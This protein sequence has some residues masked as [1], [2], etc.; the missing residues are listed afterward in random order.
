[1][2]SFRIMRRHPEG[3]LFTS[4]I[5]KHLE[6]TN[7]GQN[8]Q[9]LKE[10]LVPPPGD[11][12]MSEEGIRALIKPEDTCLIDGMAMGMKMLEDAGY[13]PRL[14]V[15]QENDEEDAEGGKAAMLQLHGE[16]D[17]TG[18]GLGFS[19][20]RTSMKGGYLEQLQHGP[21]SSAA[22]MMEKQKRDNNG[23][24][25]NV[26]KQEQA[27]KTGISEI[28]NKQKT[29]LSDA[30]L[31]DDDDIVQ[32]ADEDERFNIPGGA[33]PVPTADDS[34][35]QLSGFTSTSRQSKKRLRIV[36]QVEGLD[37]SLE[38]RVEI[39]ED[40]VVIAQYIKR[41]NEMD[42]AEKD[43]LEIIPT[44]DALVDRQFAKKISAELDRLEKNR[45]RRLQREQNKKLQ[46]GAGSARSPDAMEK[47]ITGT[48]RKCAN[49]GQV[50]H[51]KTNKKYGVFLYSSTPIPPV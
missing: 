21:Q 38:E 5:T 29:T 14:A 2:L 34:V 11:T 39:V 31:H 50:G 43:I 3:M 40:P 44:G 51:I 37:G 45:D 47:P 46:D 30:T 17:P 1:M 41:R 48:T 25:Y 18:H 28:W 6:G 49:C 42:A 36:R 16:G 13:D 9:K 20:I 19:F 12:L 4:D 35:S 22:D 27:Y 24:A 26:K 15:I 10:F 8:R 32:I 23:H 33:T 7:D